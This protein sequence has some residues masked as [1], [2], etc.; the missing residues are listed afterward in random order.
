[1]YPN[2]SDGTLQLYKGA[3]ENNKIEDTNKIQDHIVEK[4][5]QTVHKV[6][7]HIDENQ[8][9][10]ATKHNLSCG[11]MFVDSEEEMDHKNK[12]NT[13]PLIKATIENIECKILIDSGCQITCISKEFYD[14]IFK[15]NRNI[16]KLPVTGVKIVG[17]T[18]GKSRN[19]CFQ[20]YLDMEIN[21]TKFN[22]VA[23]VVEKLIH[24]VIIGTDWLYQ[25]E[26]KIDF[27]QAILQIKNNKIPFTETNE[28]G[29][30][31]DKILVV[32]GENNINANYG[33]IEENL[34]L[35]EPIQSLI[36]EYQHIFTDKPGKTNLY[37]HKIRLT[38]EQPFKPRSYPVPLCHKEKVKRKIE[39][40]TK[41]GI[42][43]RSE[44]PY[45]SPLVPIIKKDGTVRV[46]LDAQSL[47]KKIDMDY[48]SP[49]PAEHLLYQYNQTLYFSTL[50]LTSSFWQI[51]LSKEST[52][53]CGFLFDNQVYEFLV[54]PFG[55]KTA[56]AG[57]SRCI[58][59]LFESYSRF[60]SC[61]IDDILITSPSE[62][63]HYEHLRIV[64]ERL[65]EA[66]LTVNLKK[67]KFFRKEIPF[68]G[69]ILTTEG[70]KIDPTKLDTLR[71]Y[72]RPNNIRSL[73]GF[74]GICN[75]HRRFCPNHTEILHNLYELLKKGIKWK[76]DENHE[77]AF[78][79]AKEN[80]IQ[81][82]QLYHPHLDKE[83][84]METDASA[85]AIA[86]RLF[87]IIDGIQH[88]VAFY[89]RKLTSAEINY[90]TCERELL[91]IIACLLKWRT[92]IMGSKVIV[93]SDHK[94]LSFLL[95]CQLLNP[96]LT[97]WYLKIQNFNLEIKHL[98]G[99]DNIVADALSRFPY[100]QLENNKDIVIATT[101]L[102]NDKNIVRNLKNLK[103]L[104]RLDQHLSIVINKI[105]NNDKEIN[106]F[107]LHNDVLFHADKLS[108]SWKACIPIVLIDE[109][110]KTYHEKFG[111]FGVWKT[112]KSLAK[113][114]TWKNMRDTIKKFVRTCEICQKTKIA[115]QA[116]VG[117]MKSVIPKDENDLVAVDLFGPLPTSTAGVKYIFV[118]L[119]VFTKFIKLYP[120]KKPTTIMLASK[121]GKDY[122]IN[123]RTPQ[124]ILSDN[125]TQ[126]T[127][128]K[129]GEFLKN[130]NIHNLHCS[131]RHPQSN[132]SERTMREI[133]R[134]LRVYCHQKH[135]AWAKH[136]KNIELLINCAVHE[137]TEVAP[138]LAETGKHPDEEIKKIISFPDN[139][140]GEKLN[141]QLFIR[142]NILSK[143]QKR[144][145]KHDK[146][147]KFT[148]FTEGQLV[149]L[150]S[151][152][153]SS[154]EE[155]EIKKMFLLYEGPYRIKRI[156][157]HNAYLLEDR[158]NKNVRGIFNVVSLKPY[159]QQ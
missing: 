114:Y 88:T 117:K 124:R 84:H 149:W 129:W 35:P 99:E 33:P 130:N 105:E 32:M 58:N 63:K 96:R 127:S 25:E 121:L 94:S 9:K 136:V 125:G 49:Q 126:F 56:V 111:H 50:D 48:E 46:C 42:I 153:I 60:V 133:G 64:F 141:L 36:T 4:T 12:K 148:K 53:F 116:I 120:I 41:W 131:I 106:Q 22:L 119:N 43:R 27:S 45:I 5:T 75:Y 13:S 67:C 93:W 115:N 128:K 16:L 118:V 52:K 140:D 77:K 151:N 143:A 144:Q 65:H 38:D 145:F 15:Q 62:E 44:T 110:I 18:G 98:A 101:K 78:I 39:E 154:S 87:Q 47:N 139:K 152:N 123:V 30:E 17:A 109:L 59:I 142:K 89:S 85:V 57:M 97:R 40:M 2:S 91:S 82:S 7:I 66:N 147:K 134:L 14:K 20:V 100:N 69:H 70:I 8:A 90:F 138:I 68:L 54:M 19:V 156:V 104:Q 92:I 29:T 146:N 28:L 113:Y 72:P 112:Y 102:F 86:G 23:L 122:F 21:Q 159:V 55:L 11:T 24:S 73:R 132:P 10:R 135:T 157:G 95:N 81:S 79:T 61:Y 76:W 83:F 37:T 108:K 137:T 31:R 107:L 155:K 150:K 74:L 158:V 26:G 103:G 80:I 34:T 71:E 3:T 51:P 1:M 6:Q